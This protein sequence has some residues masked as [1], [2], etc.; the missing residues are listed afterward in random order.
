MHADDPFEFV[1]RRLGM[2][3]GNDSHASQTLWPRG[4]HLRDA[5]VD[6]PVNIDRDI[7]AGPVAES[8][9]CRRQHRDVDALAV[10]CLKLRIK[11]DEF[12]E[13]RIDV[14]LIVNDASRLPTPFD[15]RGNPRGLGFN[16]R[17]E[18]RG[19]DVTV[20][21]DIHTPQ[22]YRLGAPSSAY[23]SNSLSD[24]LT[25]MFWICVYSS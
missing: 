1:D 13:Q 17:N 7:A 10:H 23:Q 16:R 14:A 18:S 2:L 6:E 9:R 21:I 15:A 3:H 24:R 22:L 4:D 25:M 8:R 19:N 12:S 20:E 11:V 5:V